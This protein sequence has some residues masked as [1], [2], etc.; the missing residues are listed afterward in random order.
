M[1][2]EAPQELL[3]KEFFWFFGFVFWFHK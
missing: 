3:K 1:G 2:I